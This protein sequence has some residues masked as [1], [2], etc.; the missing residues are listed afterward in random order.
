[1]VVDP[2]SCSSLESVSIYRA[3]QWGGI[4]ELNEPGI[5]AWVTTS[6]VDLFLDNSK[7]K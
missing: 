4:R 6:S 3:E 1:M 7:G 5:F 2:W